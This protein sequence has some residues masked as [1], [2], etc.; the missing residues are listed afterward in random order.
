MTYSFLD[1]SRIMA[2]ILHDLGGADVQTRQNFLLTE[3]TTAYHHSRGMALR[4]YKHLETEA[5]ETFNSCII[6]PASSV[7]YFPVVIGTEKMESPVF[8]STTGLWFR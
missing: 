6:D 7:S 5:H 1:E 2:W 8:A 4:Q 3:I